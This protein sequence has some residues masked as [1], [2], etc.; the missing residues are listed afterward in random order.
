VGYYERRLLR[1]SE[2]ELG[3]RRSVGDAGELEGVRVLMIKM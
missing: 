3:G 1:E 2:H